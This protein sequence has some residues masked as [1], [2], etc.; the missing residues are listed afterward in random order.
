MSE[1]STMKQIN[2]GFAKYYY[3]TEKGEVYSSKSKKIIKPRKHN[4]TL[5]TM[6]GAR[7][8][9][10][11]K[12][13]YKLVYNK[14]FCNDEILDLPGE[15]WK[16][17]PKTEG[18]YLC[19]SRGRIKSL[20]GYDA[21]ILAAERNTCDYERVTIKQNGESIRKFVHHIVAETWLEQPENVDELIVHHKDGNKL[22]NWA[23]NVEYL[24]IE[25]HYKIHN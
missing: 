10:S 25:E 5:Q 15:Q 24:T 13:L 7:S 21:V 18:L 1:N 22:R 12:A 20:V 14:V 19:S 9:I 4:Y 16:E 11:L 8:S 23:D 6:S 2:N 3:L 17:I